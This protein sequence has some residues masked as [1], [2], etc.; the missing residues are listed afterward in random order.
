MG[1][2]LKELLA[3]LEDPELDKILAKIAD[4]PTPTSIMLCGVG[5]NR[6]ARSEYQEF[7]SECLKDQPI[8]GMPFGEATKYMK[9][10]AAQ[11]KAQKQ[12]H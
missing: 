10:C 1:R 5:K 12:E 6:R 2:Q 8:Q 9:R 11:W 3:T 4:C 7:M